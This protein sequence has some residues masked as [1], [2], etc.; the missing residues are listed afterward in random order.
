V[1]TKP[2]SLWQKSGEAKTSPASAVPMAL[3]I[4]V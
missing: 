2:S 3:Q 4:L 1:I